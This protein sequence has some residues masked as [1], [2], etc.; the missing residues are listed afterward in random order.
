ML[1]AGQGMFY[2][3]KKVLFRASSR[4]Y[5]KQDIFSARF[6]LYKEI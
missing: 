1:Q 6:E 3:H 2:I 5:C 4:E